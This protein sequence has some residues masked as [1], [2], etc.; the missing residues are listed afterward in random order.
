MEELVEKEA[1]IERLET[2]NR[3]LESKV[4]RLR[5][6]LEMTA[7]ERPYPDDGETTLDHTDVA[8]AAL[9]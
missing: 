8:R 7:G 5:A 9:R 3:D 6:A 2:E 4:V 1:E